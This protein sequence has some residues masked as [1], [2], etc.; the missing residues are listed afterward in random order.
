MAFER[1]WP[2]AL[3]CVYAR[4]THLGRFVPAKGTGLGLATVSSIVKENGGRISVR[5]ELGK[6][7][8]FE[9]YLPS[10]ASRKDL[11]EVPQAVVAAERGTETILTV[12]DEATLRAITSEYLQ[13]QGYKVLAA[14]NGIGALEL[15]RNHSGPIDL[16][17]TDVVLPGISGP[18]VAAAALAMRP[19]MRVI[20]VSGYIDRKIDLDAVGQGAAFLLKPY[21]LA[22]LTRKIREALGPCPS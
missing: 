20:Y 9:V 7:S 2:A 18:E 17:L 21:N 5:S 16:L 12:E 11:P 3:G 4:S 6:G 8:T 10:S 13:A 15:C 22:D 19:S 1:E 14:G